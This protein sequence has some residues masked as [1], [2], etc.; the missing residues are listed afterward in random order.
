MQIAALEDP[1]LYQDRAVQSIITIYGN[2]RRSFEDPSLDQD[3]TVTVLV[4]LN[5][6]LLYVVNLSDSEALKLST[7]QPVN[8]STSYIVSSFPTPN[9]LNNA[10]QHD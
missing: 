2:T 3:F 4:A 9:R 8:L 7:S 5:R 1:S 6:L 10:C